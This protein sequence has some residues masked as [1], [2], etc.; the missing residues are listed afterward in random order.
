MFAALHFPDLTVMA[1]L[2]AS[3]GSHG[4]PCAVLEADVDPGAIL[5]KVTLALQ[6]VNDAARMTGISAGWPLNRALVRCP[7]L[8]VLAPDPAGEADLLRQLVEAAEGITPDIEVTA[9]DTLLLDLSRTSSRHAARLADL[10]VADAW[11]LHVRAATPDLARLAVRHESCHGRTVTPRKIAALPVALLN[12]LPDGAALLPLLKDWGLA[13]LGDFMRLP[14]QDLTSRLGPQAG[15][16][17][18][19]LHGK[20]CRLLRLHRPP[21]SMAQSMDFEEPLSGTEP[22]VF[23][24]KRLL[25]ALCARLAAR[26]VAVK[27]L[28]IVFHLERGASFAR[29]IRLPEPRVE[30]GELLRP[31]QVLLDSLKTGSSATGLSLDVE[32]TLPTAAQRDWFIRQLP[33]PERWSDTLAQLEALLGPGKV[34]IPVPPLSHRPDDF[35]LLP[36][37]GHSPA[38]RAGFFPANSLPLRR[39]RPVAPVMVAA[40]A[41]P[42]QPRPLALLT[43][44]CRGQIM[45][46]RGPFRHSGHWWDPGTAWQRI[47]W[48]VRLANDQLLRLAFTPPDQWVIDG[49]YQ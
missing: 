44:P 49:L 7:D 11:P 41:H 14:R 32:T 31:I 28:K 38:D 37:D 18:D 30:E 40:D 17:H 34:G 29:E 13:T 16:W 33:Q 35:K 21:E 8:K 4:Q 12:F 2:R 42:R 3:P 47:E 48:D 25:H 20:T 9:K 26:Y 43:G 19:L 5:E 39:F 23:A 24:F 27:A 46:T 45:E 36:A 6:A 10:E 22:L 15:S 1:A